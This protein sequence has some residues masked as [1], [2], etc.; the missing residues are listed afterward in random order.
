MVIGL[1]VVGFGTSSPELLTSL[2]AALAGSPG[3]AIGNVVGSNTGNVLLLLGLTALIA[4]IAVT[5]QVLQ[6]N[7]TVLLL[8]SLLC[9]ALVLGGHRAA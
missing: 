2:Q 6:R 7:G 5:A 8:A 9:L 3:I 4:P 1:T